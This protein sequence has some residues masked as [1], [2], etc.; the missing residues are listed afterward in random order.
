MNRTFRNNGSLLY[1]LGCGSKSDSQNGSLI[2]PWSSK[3]L[4]S[5]E[6]QFSACQLP[7]FFS[8]F[9]FSC[10]WISQNSFQL[11]PPK[12]KKNSTWNLTIPHLKKGT[13]C[14]KPAC[15][16]QCII[17]DL[18]PPIL[19]PTPHQCRE[20]IIFFETRLSG[21]FFVFGGGWGEYCL[22]GFNS[23]EKYFR[24]MGSCQ[25]GWK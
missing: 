2:I 7:V 16:F 20:A 10:Q 25:W 18:H 9:A 17:G 22:G 8:I 1:E 15:H 14:S 6:I 24:Q 11:P 19:N 3:N 21:S 13:S 12:K 4:R 5:K 23:C